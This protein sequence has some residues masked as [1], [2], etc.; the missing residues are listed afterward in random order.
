MYEYDDGQ[1]IVPA[2]YPPPPRT[3]DETYPEPDDTRQHWDLDAEFAQ[4]FRPPLDEEIPAEQ[5]AAAPQWAQHGGPPQWADQGAPPPQWADQGAPPQWAD[6]AEPADPPEPADGIGAVDGVDSIDRIQRIER[7][8]RIART[9]RMARQARVDRRRRR[10]R[11]IRVR[12]PSVLGHGLAGIS[13]AVAGTISVLSAMISYGPLRV[14]AAPT[15][16]G[17]AGAWPLLV[18]GPWL[19]GCFSILHAAAHRRQVRAAWSAVIFFSGVAMALCIAHAP[20]TP[21]AIATAGLPPVSA[22]VC[23]HLLFRQITLLQPRHA[24]LPRQRRH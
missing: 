2:A 9:E 21:T 14:L 3:S 13:A 20:R 17:L 19:A 18:Y 4:F 8:E 11:F 1:L 16:H 10:R 24:K 12:W 23:F 22:L 6:P 15:A 5:Y 7:I